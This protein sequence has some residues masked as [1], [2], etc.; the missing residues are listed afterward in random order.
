[1]IFF[2]VLGKRTEKYNL[3]SSKRRQEK[4]LPRSKQEKLNYYS[5]VH[6]GPYWMTSMASS[7]AT[8]PSGY[9]WST[10]SPILAP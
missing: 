9:P 7:P 10:A 2:S 5:L 3:P 1:M 8:W 6:H 4:K